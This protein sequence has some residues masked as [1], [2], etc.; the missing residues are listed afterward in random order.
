MKRFVVIFEARSLLF[1]NI[2]LKYMHSITSQ[3]TVICPSLSIE[4]NSRA[5]ASMFVDQEFP[6]LPKRF[7]VSRH[8]RIRELISDSYH[9]ERETRS[10]IFPKYGV[11]CE[12]KVL[13]SIKT[14][15]NSKSLSEGP[16]RFQSARAPSSSKAKVYSR[17][18]DQDICVED[19]TDN[20]FQQSESKVEK[21]SIESSQDSGHTIFLPQINQKGP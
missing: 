3:D 15:V 16:P 21:Q 8:V 13:P 20:D 9:V 11:S 6:D 14:S 10:C 17:F 4:N 19:L 7:F 18:Q 12:K 1:S 2:I 5:H